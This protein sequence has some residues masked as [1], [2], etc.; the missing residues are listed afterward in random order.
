[1][2]PCLLVPIYDH[3]DTIRAVVESLRGFGLPCLVVD[4]GRHEPTRRVLVDL[5][6]EHA[7]VEVHRRPENG[8]RGAALQTGYRRAFAAGHS[9]VVQLDAD[10]Q[11]RTCDVPAFLDAVRRWPDALVLGRP[12][13]D[14]TAPRSRLW[15][16]QLS[17]VMVWAATLSF[18][19]SD[20]LC[21]FRAV[22]L[23]STLPLLDS[24]RMGVA[25]DFDPELVIRLQ[26]RG[27][28]VR[29]VPTRVVYD[30]NGLSHFQMVRDNAR[31]TWLYTRMLAGAPGVAAGHLLRGRREAR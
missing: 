4:D 27:V 6:E 11:H 7:F 12:L 2:K 30:P 15:G 17:R 3:G 23:A 1:L 29:N 16:R 13:F 31:L 18:A 19:C 5:A 22:P 25:M 24:V 26:R 20:P 10:G 9:H 28:P 21:G 14:E 8:G